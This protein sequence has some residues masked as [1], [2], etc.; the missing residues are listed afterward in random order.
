[1]K[2]L[3]LLAV[4]VTGVPFALLPTEIK[5]APQSSLNSPLRLLAETLSGTNYAKREYTSY[6]WYIKNVGESSVW[7]PLPR[8]RFQAKS[9][10]PRYFLFRTR[11]LENWTRPPLIAHEVNYE[12][13][14]VILRDGEKHKLFTTTFYKDDERFNEV[15][16]SLSYKDNVG[17]IHK[18]KLSWASPTPAPNKR[19]RRRPRSKS[20]NEPRSSSHGPVRNRYSYELEVRCTP[21]NNLSEELATQHFGAIVCIEYGPDRWPRC[22]TRRCC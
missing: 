1:M 17:E 10:P 16:V 18:E 6:T 19:M 11:V 2:L 8:D 3:L 22:G 21:M 7:L 14:W 15:E 5:S 4:I 13:D 9:A 20:R 12:T